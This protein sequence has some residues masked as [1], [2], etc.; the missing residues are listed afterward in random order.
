MSE[1]HSVWAVIHCPNTKRFLIARRGPKVNNP[2]VWNLFGGGVED[3]EKRAK[4]MIRE[5]KEEAGIRV[6]KT[7][8]TPISKFRYDKDGKEKHFMTF[9]L[10]TVESE[11]IPKLNVESDRYMW[12]SIKKIPMARHKSLSVFSTFIH[13]RLMKLLKEGEKFPVKEAAS[14]FSIVH[15]KPGIMRLE[16]RKHGV[17]AASVDFIA[18]SRRLVNCN[19]RKIVRGDGSAARMIEHAATI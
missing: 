6:E 12:A 7:A 18:S 14:E 5:L 2:K 13:K 4:S 16:M 17:T 8:L 10:L 9:Y 11:I 15:Q 1:S 19:V 3:G